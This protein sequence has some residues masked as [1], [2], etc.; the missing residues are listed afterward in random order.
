MHG[1]GVTEHSGPEPPEDPRNP[2]DREDGADDV[3]SLEDLFGGVEDP[4]NSP[5]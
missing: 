4:P 1:E 2:P 5:G 3:E